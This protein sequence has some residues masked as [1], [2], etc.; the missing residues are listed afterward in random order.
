[1]KKLRPL[2]LQL[3]EKTLKK[4][5]VFRFGLGVAKGT[6]QNISGTVIAIAHPIETINN[7]ERLLIKLDAFADRLFIGDPKAWA[8]VHQAIETFINAPTE[9]KAELFGKVYV[10]LSSRLYMERRI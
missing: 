3:Y 1:M 8:K 5:P 9:D 7:L 2:A 4:D 10:N 6:Y